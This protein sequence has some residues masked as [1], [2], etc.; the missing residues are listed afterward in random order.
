[1][2]MK[3]RITSVLLAL[4]LAI[5]LI[6][7]VVFAAQ[8]GKIT[9]TTSATNVKA[10]D[11]FTITVSMGK[12][13]NFAT[14]QVE[15]KY[16]S[17]KL[18]YIE[19]KTSGIFANEDNFFLT[20]TVSN[21][22]SLSGTV[23][24]RP[25][26]ENGTTIF[27][28]KFKVKNG[29]TGNV[30]PTLNVKA[31]QE[32]DAEYNQID[33][34]TTVN[35]ATVTVPQ[36]VTGVSLNKTALNLAV[37]T[38]EK[39]SATVKPDN[40][41]DKT[42]TWK[43]SDPSVATVSTDG[44]VT[45][46][47]A[48]KATI[49]VTTA[50]GVKT[51]TC[52]VTVVN[53]MH[54]G[55]I[56]HVEAQA[57]TCTAT[58]NIEYW[59]CADCHT[60]WSNAEKTTVVTDVT[61]AKV[62]HNFTKEVKSD[63]TLKTAGT[64]MT[65]AVYYKSCSVC[66]EVSKMDTFKG[67]KDASKH[68]GK[69]TYKSNGDGTHSVVCECDV[70]ITAKENCSGGTATCIKKAECTKCHAEYGDLAAHNIVAVTKKDATCME[71]GYEAHYKCTVCKK[72]FSDQDGKKQ[73]DEP[74]AIKA[75]HKLVKV[76][77]KPSTC[78]AEGWNEYY[79]CSV[80]G[81]L[82]SDAAGA[83]G[84]AKVPTLPLADHTPGTGYAYDGTNHWQFC[85]VCGEKLNVTKH[86]PDIE[87]PTEDQ[88]QRCKVCDAVLKNATGDAEHTHGILD[89]WKFDDNYHW[90]ACRMCNEQLD[91]AAHRFGSWVID[92]EATTTTTG[93]RHAKCDDCGYVKQEVIA[94]KNP[95]QPGGGSSTTDKPVESQK[96][97]D[98][99]IALYAG[100]AVLSLTGGA[101]MIGKKK[102]EH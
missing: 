99:G 9:V 46:K 96:T 70:V 54:E 49:T 10:G 82:F 52:T 87:E 44:T 72:L 26:V 3:K 102:K 85:T 42:V 94:K 91:K 29:V 101:W 18:E 95:S 89:G 66:G 100:M 17:T 11:E 62:P 65:E 81:K 45:A 68:T 6:P 97:F 1:M 5:S 51:A 59:E 98:A 25:T 31:L 27:T 19:S 93:L 55:T 60:K 37:N 71:D 92:K 33:I 58:G 67:D 30:A 76:D 84:I 7:T 88:A 12:V 39:L 69:N 20:D 79:K 22:I 83:T 50:D 21:E 41:T 75:A 61:T 73:I 2:K 23:M 32:M 28:S 77:A 43:S 74:V 57:A 48:G 47:K 34:A 63:K 16:D 64:C 80:C 14:L 8:T 13:T 53:C 86:T 36:G 15:L 56:K 35:Q 24:S 40:A 4:V 90:H 38:S 78:L